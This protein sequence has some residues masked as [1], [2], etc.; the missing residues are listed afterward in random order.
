MPIGFSVSADGNL[1]TNGN[2]EA[3]LK[4]TLRLKMKGLSLRAIAGELQNRGYRISHTGV[5]RILKS[6][7]YSDE[8]LVKPI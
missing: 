4:M 2:R 3:I 1:E 8:K 6:V 7:G 5:A